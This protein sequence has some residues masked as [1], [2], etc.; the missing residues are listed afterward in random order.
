[1][2]IVFRVEPIP[3][4]LGPL[5]IE[6]KRVSHVSILTASLLGSLWAFVRR[7][8]ISHKRESEIEAVAPVASRWPPP[9]GSS[10]W[11]TISGPVARGQE[12]QGPAQDDDGDGGPHAQGDGPT[13][14]LTVVSPGASLSACPQALA[15]SRPSS[16]TR[17]TRAR[18]HPDTRHDR[19]RLTPDERTHAASTSSG[20]LAPLR[21]SCA[22][23][24]R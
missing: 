17:A 18:R 9:A 4:P 14:K 24:R 23:I 2:A 11:T 15:C 10:S 19:N 20:R 1:M 8:F 16:A 7:Q 13:P 5:R 12:G 3:S 22:R 21:K 6:E